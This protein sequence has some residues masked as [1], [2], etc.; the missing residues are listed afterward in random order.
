M[1]ETSEK[2]EKNQKNAK[3]PQKNCKKNTKKLQKTTKKLQINSKKRHVS[4][5]SLLRLFASW[6]WAAVR[7]A[8]RARQRVRPFVRVASFCIAARRRVV[9]GGLRG[10]CFA[11]R[12]G[13]GGR[14]RS[15]ISCRRS[16]FSLRLA[17]GFFPE[18]LEVPADLPPARVLEATT[19]RRP[20]PC[21]VVAA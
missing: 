1:K 9:C 2:L 12:R 6:T 13:A 3:E 10:V 11:W 7:R 14:F 21:C 17:L 8:A 16:R 5:F 18:L 19:P 20:A 15:K 4:L